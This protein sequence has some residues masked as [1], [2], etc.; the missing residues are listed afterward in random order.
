ME[1]SGVV[2]E[3]GHLSKPVRVEMSPSTSIA[4]LL[5]LPEDSGT[6]IPPPLILENFRHLFPVSL[7]TS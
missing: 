3:M 1:S 7:F 6:C 5:H 2:G 4:L